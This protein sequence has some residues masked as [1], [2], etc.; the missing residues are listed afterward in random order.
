[1]LFSFT[2]P[3]WRN[4]QTR[5]TQNPVVLSTVWVRPP[6][7]GLYFLTFLGKASKT[8]I[9]TDCFSRSI[10]QPSATNEAKVA[11]FG[12]SLDTLDT[13]RLRRSAGCSE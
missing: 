6:P 5:G 4:W 3:E 9:N 7:P 13:I 11:F 10:L 12:A 8:R 1:M 2:G